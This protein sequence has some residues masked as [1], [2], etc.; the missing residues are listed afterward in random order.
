MTEPADKEPGVLE[1]GPGL[2]V[3]P[4][5]TVTA[6]AIAPV[7]PKVAPLFT[8]TVLVPVAELFG[9]GVLASSVPAVTVVPPA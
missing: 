7:P 8:V 2:S 4:L 5:L 1:L 6:P 3:P 9:P